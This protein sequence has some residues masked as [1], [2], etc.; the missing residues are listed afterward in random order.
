M[1]PLGALIAARIRDTGPMPLADYMAEC[2]MHPQ[3]GYYA[4]RDPFGRSGDFITAPEI[5]QMFGELIGLAVAQAWLEA[6]APTPFVLAEAGPGRGTLMADLWRATREVP[7]F[8]AAA[9]LWL[10]ETSPH[11]RAVQAERLA[12]SGVQWADRIEAL[13][14]GPLFLIANEFLDALPIRQFQRQGAGWAERLVGLDATGALCFGL[15]PPR[16]LAA[17]DARLADTREGDVVEINPGA[18]A[19]AAAL[20]ARIASDGGLALL[21]DY[22]DAVSLGDTFQAMRAHAPADPLAAPGLAD[23][24]AQVAFAPLVAAARAAG[25]AV[26]GPTP[27]GLWLERLG[28]TARAQRLAANLRGA[29]LEAHV[30]AHRRLTHPAEMGQLFKMIALH[31]PGLTPPGFDPEATP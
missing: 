24:T 9:R 11:L 7:G 16:P 10:V 23:L 17:L 4:T 20:G 21:I 25:A 5:S 31:S 15:T 29:A 28:I 8:H 22:G 26:A 30:A 14:P 13:P 27:Q 6:G 2:L 12:G 3:H 18:E 19:V 1:T